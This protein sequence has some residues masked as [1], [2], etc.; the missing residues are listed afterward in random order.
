MGRLVR[1]RCDALGALPR[2]GE[3][4]PT[5]VVDAL[6]SK[7]EPR[8]TPDG[9][10][11]WTVDVNN[12]TTDDAFVLMVRELIV[13]G[14]RRPYSVS[15]AGGQYPRSLDGLMRML[16]LDMRVMDAGWIGMKLR[17]LLTYAEP[18]GDFMTWVPGSGSAG[19]AGHGSGHG[20][21]RQQVYPSTVA[22]IACLLIHR[23]RMLG[24]LDPDGWPVEGGGELALRPAPGEAAASGAYLG[25]AGKKCRECGSPMMRR[26]GCDYCAGCGAMG[27]CG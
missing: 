13:D 5:P 9:T 25:T 11:S 23:Y 27:A 20:Q 8:T 14:T 1:W 15:L 24:I 22:Y 16:S 21:R 2:S 3:M 10:M 18:R 17:K 7:V 4:L 12:P 6:I 26:D 19:S